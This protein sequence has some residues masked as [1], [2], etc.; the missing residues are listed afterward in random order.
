MN[1]TAQSILSYAYSSVN[2]ITFFDLPQSFLK[3]NVPPS[4]KHIRCLCQVP[5]PIVLVINKNKIILHVA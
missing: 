5:R 1:E 4:F 2:L 3:A